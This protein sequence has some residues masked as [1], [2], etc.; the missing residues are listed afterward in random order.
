MEQKTKPRY[1]DEVEED[2]NRYFKLPAA[3]AKKLPLLSDLREY[4]AIDAVS[5]PLTPTKCL[6]QQR[7][8]PRR[9]FLPAWPF[10]R[11]KHAK[12]R[13][14][15][16]SENTL[17]SGFSGLRCRCRAQSPTWT[18][19]ACVIANPGSFTVRCSRCAGP[20]AELNESAADQRAC[21]APISQHCNCR[22]RAAL[23]HS[24]ATRGLDRWRA[25]C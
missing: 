22:Q 17:K 15:M 19:V 14:K 1:G 10:L 25:P 6:C 24:G 3:A 5:I 13:R 18:C 12:S 20:G 4:L 11:S 16:V 7:Y 23:S 8:G 9:G 2:R 21:R